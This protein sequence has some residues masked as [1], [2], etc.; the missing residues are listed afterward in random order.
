MYVNLLK[1][2]YRGTVEEQAFK[3]I[4]FYKHCSVN[5]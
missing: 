1:A 4:L 3:T 5:M 2:I